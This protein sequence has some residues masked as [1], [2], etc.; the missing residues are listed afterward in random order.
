[1]VSFVANNKRRSKLSDFVT[2]TLKLYIVLKS[3]SILNCLMSMCAVRAR[4]RVCSFMFWF[5]LSFYFHLLLFFVVF[6]IHICFIFDWNYK[7]SNPMNNLITMD[8]KITHKTKI[9]L[10]TRA[11][12]WSHNGNETRRVNVDAVTVAFLRFCYCFV[13]L[14]HFVLLKMHSMR[15]IILM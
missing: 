5:L 7:Q 14:F 8:K 3:S 1:M 4:V 10:K 13:V 6:A 9:W 12:I 2:T 11:R 15:I